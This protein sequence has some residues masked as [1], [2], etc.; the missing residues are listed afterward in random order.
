MQ[1]TENPT[2]NLAT[3]EP[4]VGFRLRFPHLLKNEIGMGDVVK[5]ATSALGIK[6]CSACQKRADLLNQWLTFKP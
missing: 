3:P 2:E 5:K 1:I 4:E 6:P